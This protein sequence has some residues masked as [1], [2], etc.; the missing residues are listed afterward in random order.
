MWGFGFFQNYGFQVGAVIGWPFLPCLLHFYSSVSC[1]LNILWVKGVVGGW[2]LFPCTG[3]ICL[4]EVAII[5]WSSYCQL[6][7]VSTRIISTNTQILLPCK[8]SSHFQRCP[9]TDFLSLFQLFYT[10]PC[11]TWSPSPLFSS[12]ILTYSFLHLSTSG[13]YFI[14]PSERK[15]SLSPLC[16][17]VS[18]NLWI[19]AWVCCNLWLMSACKFVHI[20]CVFLF[21]SCLTQD[22]IF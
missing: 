15:T 5:W 18:M 19:V 17:F 4:L 12:Y 16:K 20:M 1:R 2:S 8:V 22:Q 11:H 6:P 21:H 13:I 7:G 3:T 9:P 10:L 14:T